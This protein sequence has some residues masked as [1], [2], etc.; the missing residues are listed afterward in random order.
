MENNVQP[1]ILG[2]GA[3]ERNQAFIVHPYKFNMWIFILTLIM[4]FGG[5]TSAYIVSRSFVPL[6]NIQYFMLPKVMIYNTISLGVSSLIM[7]WGTIQAKKGEN[8]K[9][10]LAIVGAL[11]LGCIFMIGQYQAFKDM[12]S[13]GNFLSDSSR[14]DQSVSFFYI[15]TGLHAVHILSAVIALLVGMYKVRSNRFK[16]T[17]G[18]H[19]MMQVISTFW[20]FLGLLWLYLYFFLLYTQRNI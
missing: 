4:V 14:K 16:T 6:K 13:M 17:D 10:F 12:I 18:M 15:L 1:S 9:V 20:H 7:W 11:L 8:Q 2:S 5:F 3:T 19:L